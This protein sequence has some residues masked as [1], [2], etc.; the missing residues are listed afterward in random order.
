LVKRLEQPEKEPVLQNIEQYRIQMAGISTAAFGYWEESDEINP[1]YDTVALRDVAKLYS[2][3]DGLFKKQQLGN[4]PEKPQAWKVGLEVFNSEI[5]A[6]NNIRN[7][8]MVIV[9]LYAA[10]QIEQQ[11]QEPVAYIH[12]SY[13]YTHPEF[14]HDIP[15]G[16]IPLYSQ[17]RPATTK[18]WTCLTDED[19]YAISNEFEEVCQLHPHPYLDID[20]AR[21]I[22]AKL[23]EKNT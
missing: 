19:I 20:Y 12:N 3:Y 9:P 1:S 21:A 15:E 14:M 17:P 16:A 13:I 10:H 18:E 2:K 23:K 8:S 4:A 6:K 22:E 5:Q 11:A 7:P